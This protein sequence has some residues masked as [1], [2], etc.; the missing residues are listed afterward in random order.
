MLAFI[1]NAV[2]I[3]F[4]EAFDMYDTMEYQG[5]WITL[6]LTADAIYLADLIII[7]PRLQFIE[8]GIAMVT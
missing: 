3:P 2:T 4:R 6:D 5:F 8:H 1:Y 7:K